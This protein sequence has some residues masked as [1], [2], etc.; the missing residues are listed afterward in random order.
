[1]SSV[2]LAFS[3]SRIDAHQ[4]C[5]SGEA[6]SEFDLCVFDVAYGKFYVE[7]SIISIDVDKNSMPRGDVRDI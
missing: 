1:M 2:L 7:L 5:I 6:L 4:D 3:L